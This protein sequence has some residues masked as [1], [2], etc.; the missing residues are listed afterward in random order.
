MLPIPIALTTDVEADLVISH[1]ALVPRYRSAEAVS[2][3]AVGQ[4]NIRRTAR[5]C[6]ISGTQLA[7]QRQER[8]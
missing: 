5:G 1:W 8:N 2:A 3:A 4:N 7:E 6:A